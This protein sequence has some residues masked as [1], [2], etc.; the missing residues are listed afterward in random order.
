[1]GD[2]PLRAI[3]LFAG[4]G[5]MS[6][7]FELAGIE[8]VA[9]IEYCD[10]AMKTHQHN[11]PNHLSYCD[12]ICNV[13]TSTVLADLNRKGIYKKDIDLVI[14][15]PPCPGFSN[16]GRSKI[17]SL[18]RDKKWKWKGRPPKEWRHQF[19]QD[20]RNKLFLEFVRF[21]KDFEPRGFVME[22]VTGMLTSKNSGG[23]MITDLI[24]NSFN[25]IGYEC[26]MKVLHA[27]KLGV[28]Q[29]R[30]RVIFIGWKKDSPQ[31]EF[32]HPEMKERFEWTSVD[33]ISDLPF[34]SPEGGLSKGKHGKSQNEYQDLMR[35]KTYQTAERIDPRTGKIPQ[36]K[37]ELSCHYG[38]W[39]NPR[40]RA[41][42]PELQT[43]KNGK[44]KTYDQIDPAKLKFP[45]PWK[46]DAKT[47]LVRNVEMKSGRNQYKWYR[48]DSFKDKIRRIPAHKPCPT[49]VAHMATDTYMYVHPTEDRTLTPQEA[50][51]IQSF[52]DSFDF[53]VVPFT[54]QYR[55]IG[56][57]VPPF[58]AKAI[59]EEI[60]RSWK[61]NDTDI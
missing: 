54:S 19:V 18:L 5:G 34:V 59:A 51:R 24:H 40:D 3:D 8:V 17:I 38:R 6:L 61:H 58:M 53:S 28:P 29:A 11:F 12:D 13:E 39:V 14:G 30:K 42:F 4:A 43:P 45:S 33:A 56:N 47:R 52:P 10:K 44:R 49:L 50:A 57:A 60:L 41:I 36:K 35:F 1:M 31:D 2:D 48:T 27:D 20:P 32:S 23:Q 7:G 16:I 25:E 46:W 55:Q 26:S 9:A 22:N 15:G 21:V 37:V